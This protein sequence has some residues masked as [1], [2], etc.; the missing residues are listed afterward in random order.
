M[1]HTYTLG[2]DFGTLSAR[3]VIAATDNGA[4][5]GM[6]SI[7]YPHGVIE[8]KMPSGAQLDPNVALQHP[9]DWL[10]CAAQ[11]V[12][13][14]LKESGIKP[15]QI[16]GIGVDFTSCTMLPVL[17]DGTP[18][19]LTG[20]W[21][22][23]LHAWPK[24]WKHHGAEEESRLLTELA[25]ERNESWLWRYGGR[26]GCEWLFPKMLEV[27]RK[28]PDVFD[29][30]ELWVEAGDWFVWQL[31]SGPYPLCD[32]GKL[33]AS[34]CQAGYK[35]LW[36]PKDGHPSREYLSAVHPRFADVL[37]G[38][39]PSRFGAPGQRAGLLTPAA[40]DK[41]GLI[42]GIP[43]A[44]ATIDAHA[45]VPG[46]GVCEPDTLVMVMGTSSCHMLMSAEGKPAPGVAGIVQNGILP[47]Y[48]GY[49]TGQACVGD[50]F[51][52]L[53]QLLGRSHAELT[54][55]SEKLPPGSGGVLALDWFNG[56]RTPLMD[57]S[58]TGAFA[59]LTLATKPQ[60]MYR[61]ALEASAMGVRWIVD[62]LRQSGVPVKKFVASGGLPARSPLLMQIYA[63]VLG[64]PIQLA[65]SSQSVALGA[66]IL[67]MLA[68][69]ERH[70]SAATQEVVRKMA[71]CR[72]DLIYMPV[73]QNVTAYQPLYELYRQLAQGK[74]MLPD[75]LRAL[76]EL[77]R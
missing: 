73:A 62:T 1:S 31:V 9:D 63:D 39:L 16:L 54:D 77:A 49:E 30:A 8:Q 33:I 32:S 72:S 64:A 57:A 18:L 13:G 19:F 11:A 20:Q 48:W 35:G 10:T 68:A 67:G 70:D 37:N 61:A 75:A 6:C 3:A 15:E 60:H 4:I 53:T 28:A 74:M 45:G 42:A 58:L 22:R 38:R 44:V 52:W 26:I 50:G 17:R 59:G 34:T 47:G 21:A 23:N 55:L 65:E 56:C 46:S 41:L 66:A 7:D 36:S 14:A 71:R 5:A 24:L 40:A 43:V 29:A 51:A 12:R 25:A 27:L 2:L 76:H 69:Q